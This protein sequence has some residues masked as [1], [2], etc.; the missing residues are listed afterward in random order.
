MKESNIEVGVLVM[1]KLG[2]TFEHFMNHNMEFIMSHPHVLVYN[3][4]AK[5]SYEETI[6]VSLHCLSHC[7]KSMLENIKPWLGHRKKR[8][9]CWVWLKADANEPVTRSR[10]DIH[11]PVTRPRAYTNEPMIR[12]KRVV[13]KPLCYHVGYSS[14]PSYSLMEQLSNKGRCKEHVTGGDM[15]PTGRRTWLAGDWF[16]TR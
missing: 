7:H 11:E 12:S 4:L 3:Q 14:Y 2:L 13:R 16:V 15:W 10:K 9:H 1:L 6:F 8:W 5:C